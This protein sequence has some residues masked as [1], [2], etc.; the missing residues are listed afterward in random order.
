MRALISLIIVLSLSLLIVRIGTVALVMTGLSK[1]VASFQATSA[2]SGVGFTTEESEQAVAYPSRR[3]AIRTLAILGNI[4]AITAV[5]SL[6]LTFTRPVGQTRRLA[7]LISVA[8]L[9]I[10]ISR[11]RWFNYLLTPI[12]ERG[13]DYATS[14]EIQDYTS[15]L[16]L[17]QD[18]SVA[19]LSVSEGDWLAS[20]EIADLALLDEGILIL[21]IR[22]R[23][24]TYIGAP[25]SDTRIRPGD[26]V[27]AYG[28]TDRL[29]ELS[30]RSEGDRTAHEEAKHAHRKRQ[31]AEQERNSEPDR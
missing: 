27:V 17:H 18:Y 8:L 7:V 25:S 24:G 21:G 5:A 31:D 26:T 22:R 13:L 12:I 6:I 15:L 29:R 30:D 3:K 2:F 11:S 16:R 1:D 14:I 20:E 23:D 28:R 10:V 4:G 9:L 19:D